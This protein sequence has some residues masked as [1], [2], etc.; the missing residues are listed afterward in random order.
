MSNRLPAR[1]GGRAKRTSGGMPPTAKRRT[2]EKELPLP[3]A[4]LPEPAADNPAPPEL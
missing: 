1:R 2:R 3:P 4:V